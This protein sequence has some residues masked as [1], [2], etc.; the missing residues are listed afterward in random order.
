[1]REWK[2]VG[3]I[4]RYVILEY[5]DEK[6]VLTINLHPDT[7]PQDAVKFEQDMNETRNHG[8]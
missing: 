7:S 5:L 2:L 8:K 3:T 6:H 1:M 4:G